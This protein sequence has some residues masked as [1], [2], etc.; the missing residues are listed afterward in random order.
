MKFCL[1]AR[2]VSRDQ[3][4]GLPW[5][6][7][8]FGGRAGRRSRS[9]RWRAAGCG[10]HHPAPV[11]QG[12]VPV[13]APGADGGDQPQPVVVARLARSDPGISTAS[14]PGITVRPA[15]LR[16]AA[17][18][19]ELGPVADAADRGP[20]PDLARAQRAGRRVGQAGAQNVSATRHRSRKPCSNASSP[21]RSWA[22]GGHLG[23]RAADRAL[24]MDNEDLRAG[25]VQRPG[26][27]AAARRGHRQP[28]GQATTR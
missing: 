4:S 24:G 14:T 16:G 13:R 20:H 22:P 23:R 17:V 28:S 9:D 19:A 15:D 26:A 27:S 7:R 10:V 8:R 6:D 5:A 12:G 25:R 11:P 3:R 21:W 2:L 1:I 18:E